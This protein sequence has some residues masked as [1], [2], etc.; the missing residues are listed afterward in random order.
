MSSADFDA[1][2]KYVSN[3]KNMNASNDDKLSFYKYFKQ[4]TVGDCNK[5]Q[6]GM[7][8]VQEGYKWDAWNGV[9]GMAKDAAKEAYVQ[10]LD[11]VAPSWRK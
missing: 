7:L 5:P 6:P 3:T 9:R 10:L 2:V 1:A 8:Q 4:A 11:K